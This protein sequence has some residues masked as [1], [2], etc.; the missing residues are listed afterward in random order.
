MSANIDRSY[1]TETQALLDAGLSLS[2]PQPIKDSPFVA[3]HK[4]MRLESLEQFEARPRRKKCKPLF[5]D[6]ASF[7]SY[8]NQYKVI[9]PHRQMFAKSD[10][11]AQGSGTCT[12]EAIFDFHSTD[13]E[14]CTDR[15]SY[16]L[17]TA[18]EWRTW[19]AIHKKPMSQV[20]FAEFIE[21]NAKDVA[22][23]TGAEL[24]ELVNEIT[25][26]TDVEFKSVVRNGNGGSSVNY[27]ENTEARGKGNV[28]IPTKITLGLP[29][30]YRGARYEA[31]AFLRLRIKER[32][33]T[34]TL[35]L[36]QPERIF[37]SAFNDV[38]TEMETL[39][40]IK[41]LVGVYQ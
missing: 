16:Q 40:T 38:L 5:Y 37:H 22:E 36:A 17:E 29:V 20:D 3:V 8:V 32:Q 15:A 14:W 27:E 4:D 18:P 41:P 25:S 34:I 28:V 39:T 24:L 30:F 33:M 23:P 10:V 9:N 35:E 1:N 11:N 2:K 6:A 26:K 21:T 19:L 13:P 31:E 12:V 7:A